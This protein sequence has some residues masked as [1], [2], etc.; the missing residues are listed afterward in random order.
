VICFLVYSPQNDGN[1][2]DAM[3]TI[4]YSYYFVMRRFVPLLRRIGVVIEVRDPERD[5]ERLNPM[6][7]RYGIDVVLLSFA[8]PN[9]TPR[10]SCVTL[11]V[12][13]WEYSTIPSE[14]WAGDERHNWQ[15]VLSGLRG[16][17]THS[18][19]AV[20]ATR[21]ALGKDYPLCS[22]P[23]PLWDDYASH[24]PSLPESEWRLAFTGVVL[25]SSEL[26]LASTHGVVPPVLEP[27]N[28]T[29]RLWGVVYAAVFNPNDGRK[30]WHDT[31]W[32]FCWAFRDNVHVTLLIKLVHHDARFACEIL[33]HE[34]KKLAP[35]RCRVV[36]IHGF[37][38]DE[39]YQTMVHGVTYIVNSSYG[40]GQCLPLMEFMSAGKP[41]L[42]PDHSAMADYLRPDNAFIVRSWP[43]WTHWPHDPRLLLRTFRHRPDWQSL[44][45]AYLQS[46]NVVRMQP[47]RYLDMSRAASQAQQRYCSRRV[48]EDGLRKFLGEL[49]FDGVSR[50][51]SVPGRLILRLANWFASRFFTP[52]R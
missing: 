44:Y 1:I 31:L 39:T 52:R 36:V 23:A 37:L 6:L 15:R 22:L 41:A 47:Q 8:P 16:A 30:N 43:E 18:Q 3:G 11:P 12:F 29:V 7:Q 46:F 27:R 45:D 4:D 51:P 2:A 32:A 40:E 50:R 35:F 33:L 24:E 48:V 49:G 26:R 28:Q 21:K 42:A 19:F 25:D 20:E 5:A 9:K 13:A 34:M 10:L 14:S 38:D 17:I